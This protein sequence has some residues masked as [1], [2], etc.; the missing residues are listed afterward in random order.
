MNVAVPQNARFLNKGGKYMG[1]DGSLSCKINLEKEK[2]E[3]MVILLV[4]D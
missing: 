2:K 1:Q 4:H 3:L